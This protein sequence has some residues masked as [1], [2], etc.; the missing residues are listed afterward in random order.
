MRER[1]FGGGRKECMPH[2]RVSGTNIDAG[3]IQLKKDTTEL[4]IHGIIDRRDKTNANSYVLNLYRSPNG[5]DWFPLV[6]GATHDVLGDYGAGAKQGQE[7]SVRYQLT[8]GTPLPAGSW[9]WC[10]ISCPNTLGIAVEVEA[11]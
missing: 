1:F 7:R 8:L 5:T 11:L 6:E 3:K 4:R 2:A 9:L 10:K